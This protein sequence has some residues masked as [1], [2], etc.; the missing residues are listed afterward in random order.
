VGIFAY[1]LGSVKYAFSGGYAKLATIQGDNLQ[2]WLF[3]NALVKHRVKSI[4]EWNPALHKRP[5][6]VQ[7]CISRITLEAF[8]R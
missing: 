8:E 3:L 5:N 2:D 6:A 1:P 7:L 4:R